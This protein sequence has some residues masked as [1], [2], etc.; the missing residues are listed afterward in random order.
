MTHVE[1][2]FGNTPFNL[3]T[4]TSLRPDLVVSLNSDRTTL[5]KMRD[6]GMKVLVLD[7]ANIQG[8]LHD[9]QLVGRATGAARQAGVVTARMK[10]QLRSV[11]KQLVKARTRPRVYYEIDATNPTQPYTAGPGTFIDEV[12][13]LARGRNVAGGVT[14]LGCPGTGCYPQLSLEALVR[15]DPQIILLG[16]AAYG[17]KV[18]DVKSRSGWS[19]ISAIRS[20]KVYPFNDELISRAGPRIMIGLEKLARRV[21]AEAF[22]RS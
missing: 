11:R 7:P 3:E 4:I 14:A 22:R 19:T 17:T 13:R 5:Q 6:L 2:G 16:D 10:Q 21:H 9:V 18:A 12:V 15:L 20:G 1:G 8:I